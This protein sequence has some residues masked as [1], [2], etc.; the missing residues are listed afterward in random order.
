MIPRVKSYGFVLYLLIIGAAI[1]A[2]GQEPEDCSRRAYDEADTSY[3]TRWRG[4][5]MK[6]RAQRELSALVQKCAAT[7][8]RDNAQR[9]LQ[10]V[11]EELAEHNLQIAKFYLESSRVSSG[12]RAGARARLKDVVERYPKYTKMDEVLSLLGQLYMDAGELEDA[13]TCYRK[14]VNEFSKSRYATEAL[15]QLS[16]IDAKQKP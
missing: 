6:G 3:R 11:Q 14:L 9:Q 2:R 16:V 12:R 13:A 1:S 4:S 7:P 15:V 8:E 5:E 10:I